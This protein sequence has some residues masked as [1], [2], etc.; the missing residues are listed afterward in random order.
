MKIERIWRAGFFLAVTGL[1]TQAL[2]ASRVQGSET[3]SLQQDVEYGVQGGQKLLMDIYSPAQAGPKPWPAIVLIHGGGWTSFDKRTM[4]GMGNFL[5]KSGFVAASVDYRL[6]HENE[7]R[8]PAQLDDVQRAV[9]WLRANA[10]KHNIDSDHIG[11]F[12]HSAGAQLAALLG[13]EETRDNSDATLANYSSRVQAVVDV[14]GPSDFL[15]N[16]DADGDAMLASFFGGS[17]SK[18]PDVWRDASPI[19][20]VAKSNAAF[21]IIHGTNDDSVPIAQSQALFD[22]LRDAGVAVRFV[23]LND[24]HMFVA[25]ESRHRMALESLAFFAQYLVGTKKSVS[26]RQSGKADPVIASGATDR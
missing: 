5:A 26:E 22:K 12:G 16:H 25:P 10:A 23:K 13:M 21:L 17:S 4:K 3:V 2:A 6:F 20:H 8:W 9:R 7:N 15:S 1:G 11:A 18:V 14:S 24:G 19:D